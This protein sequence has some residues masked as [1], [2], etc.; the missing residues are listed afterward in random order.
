MIED[1]RLIAHRKTTQNNISRMTKT[2]LN[3][4]AYHEFA[5]HTICAHVKT[6][7]TNK[8]NIRRKILSSGKRKHG[9]VTT[10]HENHV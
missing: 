4:K 10:S 2:T 1:R 6:L 3:L 7:A 8:R 9:R 5:G